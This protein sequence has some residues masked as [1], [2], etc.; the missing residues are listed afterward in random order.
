VG[1]VGEVGWDELV[2]TGLGEL[3]VSGL[4]GGCDGRHRD[5]DGEVQ[6][7]TVE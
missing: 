3:G 6:I 2:R 4:L 1:L 7:V 5:G